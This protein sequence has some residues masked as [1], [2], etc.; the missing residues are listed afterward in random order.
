MPAITP[1]VATNAAGSTTTSSSFVDASC[2]TA[3]LDN[4]VVYLVLA[5]ASHSTEGAFPTTSGSEMEAR[6][7]T[8]RYALSAFVGPFANF[9]AGDTANGG[10]LQAAFTVTGDGSST[11]NMR[12]RA[13]AGT[14]TV[15][16]GSAQFIAIP[17]TALTLNTDYWVAEASNSDSSEVVATDATWVQGAGGGQLSFTPGTTGDYLIVAS[18]EGFISGTIGTQETFRARLRQ[19]ATTTI[20][21]GTETSLDVD[22]AL[23]ASYAPSLF[24]LDVVAGTASTPIAFRWEFSNDTAGDACAYRRS[25]IYAIRLDAFTD[26]AAIV[27]GGDIVANAGDDDAANDLSFDFG[28]SIPTLVLANCSHQNGGAFGQGYLR[29]GTT[30]YPAAGYM[31]AVLNGGTGATDDNG[32]LTFATV[33]T[34]TGAQSWLLRGH[35]DGASDLTYGRNVG[36]TTSTR[37]PVVAIDLSTPGGAAELAEA[38]GSVAL[39]GTASVTPRVTASATGAVGV[40]G[41]AAASVG[42]VLAS[43]TGHAGI[44]GRVTFPALPS[45]GPSMSIRPLE[46]LELETASLV[47]FAL[48]ITPL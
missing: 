39:A 34:L 17:L 22:A 3:A 38:V 45:D 5:L 19:D 30:N 33:Q 20:G 9:N 37:T 4:G 36:N 29:D 13:N 32:W 24:A 14:D 1:I 42:A 15:R 27:D 41:T 16:W 18:S 21:T 35:S 2:T 23:S 12:V 40:A 8:T 10:I 6:F 7:G 28:S 48:E 26:Y 25:R 47:P 43:A 44:A 46:V 11:L 31:W